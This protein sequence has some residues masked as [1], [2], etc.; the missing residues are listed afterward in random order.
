MEKAERGCREQRAQTEKGNR[1]KSSTMQDRIYAFMSS[2]YLQPTF[3]NTS[4]PYQLLPDCL[5]QKL[6][7]SNTASRFG[8]FKR[9][10]SR[11]RCLTC[12]LLNFMAHPFAPLLVSD[13]KPNYCSQL[14][15]GG[16]VQCV[17]V[18]TACTNC[19]VT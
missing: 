4:T 10:Q 1:I 18:T 7:P 11:N 14:Q 19:E 8:S 2:P 3:R 12:S 5:Y 13:F 6:T 9:S 17:T 15:H 16:T